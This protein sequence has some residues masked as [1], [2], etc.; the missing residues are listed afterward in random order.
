MVENSA[1]YRS[2]GLLLLVCYLLA[3]CF[4]SRSAHAQSIWL[5]PRYGAQGAVDFMD[6]FRP[7]APWKRAAS[8][9]KAFEFS[10][11][12]QT[13]GSD[14]ELSQIMADL[15]RR[16]IDLVL[17][18]LPNPGGKEVCGHNVESY[19]SPGQ[20]LVLAKKIKSLGG[21]PGFYHM[22]E[23]LFYGHVYDGQNAC[24]SSIA[25]I[26]RD[27]AIT[28]RQIRT[29]FPAA[30]IGDVEPIMGFPEATW[31]DD[32]E[33]WIEAYQRATGERLASFCVD[34]TWNAPWQHRMQQLEAL[35]KAKGIELHVI[36]NGNG[37]DR[38]DEEWVAHAVQHFQEFES[39]VAR[40][41]DVV[42]FM[43]WVAHP[44][45]VLPESDP[46]TMTGLVDRYLDWKM[47]RH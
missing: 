6:L 46:R 29:I 19:S 28:I 35:L 42:Q 20:S 17:D 40:V 47:S 26:A 16:R 27:V 21:E 3:C 14:S 5:A 24:H 45:R 4:L 18:M 38:S 34:I 22:D 36:Y 33:Q 8:H 43:S 15:R 32:I 44:T 23:P 31:R 41:P 30:K 12:L 13:L 39:T 1:R 7:D 11:R 37:N 2:S 10:V 25:Q 9:V